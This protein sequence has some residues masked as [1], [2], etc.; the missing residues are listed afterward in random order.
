M[1]SNKQLALMTG[2]LV[3]FLIAVA[4]F[5][6][7]DTL[8]TRQK[9]QKSRGRYLVAQER[10]ER[11]RELAQQEARA[12][13]AKH[14]KK[15]TVEQKQKAN[16]VKESKRKNLKGPRRFFA[17]MRQRS[18]SR[19][20]KPTDFPDREFTEEEREILEVADEAVSDADL[21]TAKDLA[22][23]ALKSEDPRIRLRAVEALTEFGEA[24]LPE[25]ADFLTDRHEEVANLA[26][27]RFEL[28]VQEIED[29]SERVAVAKLG[30]LTVDDEDKLSSL[31]GTL[32]MATDSK[33]VI[34]ALAD[35][36]RDGSKAQAEAAKE[37]YQEETGEEWKGVEAA[38]KWLQEN[39]EPPEPE[40]TEEPE[41]PEDDDNSDDS[42][43]QEGENT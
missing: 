25:M 7:Y 33:L 34:S 16:K 19:S 4:G 10:I 11:A 14:G 20:G 9:I 17:S 28:G 12:E 24:G 40:E 27:D 15:A 38:D 43:D 36:I 6:F 35:V 1:K 2:L 22:A 18:F 23:E 21:E 3:A 41:V 39:Y 32:R 37:A 30:L 5:L 42:N 29:D 8:A 26:A 13:V 31:A